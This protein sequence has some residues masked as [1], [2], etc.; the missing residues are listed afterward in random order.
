M[1]NLP[2]LTNVAELTR[3][4]GALTGLFMITWTTCSGTL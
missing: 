1:S 3:D 2:A 4:Q